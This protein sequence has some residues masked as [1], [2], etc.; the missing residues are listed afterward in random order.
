A[1]YD[2]SIH[3]ANNKVST[4]AEEPLAA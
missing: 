4:A 2:P 3:Q 1:C